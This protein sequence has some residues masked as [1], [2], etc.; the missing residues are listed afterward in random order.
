MV[1]GPVVHATLLATLWPVSDHF[2]GSDIGSCVRNSI[3]ATDSPLRSPLPRTALPGEK[4]LVT[5]GSPALALADAATR[6]DAS[7]V[8]VAPSGQA[9]ASASRWVALPIDSCIRF[10]GR[11]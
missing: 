6:L 7:F 1:A 11:S 9:L 3:A 8:V 10:T 2:T 4:V 5:Q